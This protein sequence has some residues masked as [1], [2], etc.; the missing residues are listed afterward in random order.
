MNI[1]FAI[2]GLLACGF[3]LCGVNINFMW[4]FD[5]PAYLF[6]IGGTFFVLG[7]AGR[8]DEFFKTLRLAFSV[9]RGKS[10]NVET[11]KCAI[12]TNLISGLLYA[13]IYFALHIQEFGVDSKGTFLL[14][15]AVCGISVGF[16]CFI[17]L[18]LLIV[19]LRASEK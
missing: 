18:L 8:I 16:A 11:V 12:K 17:D 19:Q 9:E 6:V 15:F 1:L 4:V 3:S 14:R 7:L 10:C 2:L 13:C 5:L